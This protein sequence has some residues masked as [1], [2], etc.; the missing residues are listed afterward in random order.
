LIGPDA[1]TD[2]RRF[3]PN[4]VVDDGGGGYGFVE[5]EWLDGELR[6]GSQ[7]RITQLLPALRCVMTTHQQDELPRGLRILRALAEHHAARL[8]VFASI[9]APGYVRIGNPVW[10]AR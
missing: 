1:Q 3:R 7:V 9:A 10:L 8:G 4:I 5:D 6:V 2:P